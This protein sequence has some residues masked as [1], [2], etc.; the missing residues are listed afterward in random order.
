MCIY[1]AF[2]DSHPH[3]PPP[4]ELNIFSSFVDLSLY[5]Y[6]YFKNVSHCYNKLLRIAFNS[7][8]LSKSSTFNKL[9]FEANYYTGCQHS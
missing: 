3:L 4:T 8:K 5:P 7:G 9:I 2:Y 6:Q 1:E